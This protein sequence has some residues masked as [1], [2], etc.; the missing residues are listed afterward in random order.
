M[1]LTSATWEEIGRAR[2]GGNGW[3]VRRLHPES[4]HEIQVARRSSDDAIGLLFEVSTRSMPMGAALP[5]C[6]GFNTILET[7]APG[8]SGSCRICLVLKDQLYLEIFATLANDIV[9]RLLLIED[10]PTA[11]RALL[12]RLS[13]WQRFL[14]KFGIDLLTVEE[15]AG[16]FAELLMLETELVPILGATAAVRSWRGPFGEPHDFRWGE[17]AVEVK[18]TTGRD[19]TAFHVANLQQLDQ[20]AAER[21]FLVHV[22]LL[23]DTASGL[24]L[25]DLV[26][27]VR[28][29]LASVDPSAASEFGASLQEAGFLDV[30]ADAYRGRRLGVHACR[31][32]EVIDGFPRLTAASVPDGIQTARC[33]VSLTRC[34]PFEVDSEVPRRHLM[35]RTS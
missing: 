26:A 34:A 15:Q 4:Q 18:A 24:S 17:T 35:K 27:R 31:W 25:P 8:P 14:E 2:Q 19:P 16:L 32:F 20:G 7:I 13:T 22:K 5:D 3:L 33:S 6:V 1:S 10:E 12:S 21:L 30:Q 29:T 11:V 9:E 23:S 28:A